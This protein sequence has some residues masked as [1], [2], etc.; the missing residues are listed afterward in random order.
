MSNH[1]LIHRITVDVPNPSYDKRCKYGI[2]SIKT[3]KANSLVTVDSWVNDKP[4]NGQ[5]LIASDAYSIS[6]NVA[7]ILCGVLC[8]AKPNT[9]RE[10][11][12]CRGAAT[13]NINESLLQEL[14][15]NGDV[16]IDQID[17]GITRV[18]AKWDAAYDAA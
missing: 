8:D 10:T 2:E 5:I 9:V 14:L 6:G 4:W 1:N 3:F 15:D 17:A 7:A 18:F 16:T 11:I 12:F 13:L